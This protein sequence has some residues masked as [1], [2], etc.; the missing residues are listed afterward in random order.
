MANISSNNL[1]SLYGGNQDTVITTTVVPNV[2]GTIPSRNLTTLYS[3]SGAPVTATTPYGNANVE[4]FLNI[5]TDGANTVEN[6][7]ANGNITANYYFGN[8][9]FL[10]GIGNSNFSANANYANFAGNAFSV[11]IANVVGIGNIAVLNLDGNASNILFGN[12]VFSSAPNTANA[13]Y[14]NF[15]GNLINGTSNVSIPVVNGNIEFSA[16]GYANVAT[17]S[18]IAGTSNIGYLSIGSLIWK[19]SYISIGASAGGQPGSGAVYGIR[20]GQGAGAGEGAGQGVIGIGRDAGKLN[21]SGNS[22][23]IGLTAGQANQGG[24]SIAIGTGA[25]GFNQGSYTIAIGTLAGNANQ[26]N[27]SIILNATG[28]VL[29][30]TTANTFTV[31]PVRQA[32]TSNVMYYDNTTGEI[33]YDLSIAPS[34]VA[35]ANY[36][37]FAGTAFN[38]SGS[39]V[40]GEVANAAYANA[41]NTANLATFATTANAVAGAN[42]SGEVAN[43]NFASYAN[44]AASANSVALANVVGIGNIA[45]INLDGSSSNV[46]FGNGVFAPESTSIANANYANFAGNL[47]NGT[48]NITIPVANGN[49]NFSVNNN[50]NI[51]TF[52]TGGTLRLFPT[53]SAL[54]ALRIDSYGNPVANDVSRI[55]SYRARGNATTPLSVNGSDR[56]MRLLAFGHNGTLPQTSSVGTFQAQVDSSY[57]PNTANIPIGWVLSV[58]DTSAGNNQN[59]N[60]QFYANGN[61]LFAN[62]VFV[63]DSFTSGGN[64]TSNIGVFVGNGSGLNNLTGANVTGTVA[65]ATYAA[66]AGYADNAGNALILA[67][68]TSN[69][70]I[71]VSNGNVNISANGVANILSVQASGTTFF[72]PPTTT[73]GG[74]TIDSFGNPLGDVHRINSRRARGNLTTP[75][76][77]NPGDATMRLLTFGHNGANYQTNS[78][79][80]FRAQVDSSYVANGANIPI[81]WNM[82][83]NDTNGGINNQSKTHNFYSNGTV[84][85]ANSVSVTGNLSVT[86][87]LSGSNLFVNAGTLT[88]TLNVGTGGVSPSQVFITGDKT[89]NSAFRIAGSPFTAIMDNINPTTGYSPFFFNTYE[90]SNTFI[91]PSRYFRARGTEASPVAVTANDV[92]QLSSYA[93]YADSGNTYKDVIQ[94]SVVVTSNDGVGNVAGDFVIQG[95]NA[96][97][98]LNITTNTIAN[99]IS[100]N[101]NNFMKLSFYTAAALTAITGQLGWIAAVTNSTPGGRI[102]YWDTTNVRWSYVADDSA[103]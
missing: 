84:T 15:A 18:T 69:I 90:N 75:L 97:S 91:P 81:G 101:S 41:A 59:K 103:V 42:V 40:S 8:G 61:V 20:I 87:G 34:N 47:I 74:L 45:N 88:N 96:N 32:N 27:N 2:A 39:N 35:N 99:N 26:A 43:A 53:T 56:L 25:G 63:T 102:A 76:S 86:S 49:I 77:V 10:T 4:R 24:N 80:S 98:K 36:A 65:N 89:I 17:I 29:D 83:V 78:T 38:V 1:T 5:G 22:I 14:A 37:N 31:K 3:G 60:H 67:N 79:A 6:I 33:T 21:Q 28:A 13:N 72:T 7:I 93:V 73:I 71:P 11:N 55:A 50:P 9:S 66:N 57:T 58:N 85:F 62:S 64:I 48:S 19:S 82:T 95:F 92:V 70:S 46:L 100:I 52:D 44:I 12:G 94:T 51:A 68:G 23:A 54:N 30:Q 16:N